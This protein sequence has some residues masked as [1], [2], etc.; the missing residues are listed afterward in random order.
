MSFRYDIN[1][2]RAI[3]VIAVVI[4]HF[5]PSLLPGGFS[6]VDIFFVISGFLM[7]KII[8]SGFHNGD[9]NLLKFY[10]ARANRIIPALSIVCLV[11]IV[12]GWFYLNPLD[13]GDLGKHIASSLGFFSNIVYLKES[14]YFDAEAH[15]KWLLH[16]WSLSVEWQFYIIYP[17]VLVCLK[18]YLTTNKIRN[19]IL[20]SS[21]IGFIAS[22]VITY[23]WPNHAYY[24][25]PA[26]AWEMM[27]GGIAFLYP[28]SLSKKASK[29][30][31]LLGFSLIIISFFIYSNSTPWPGHFALLPV[32]GS[33]LIIISNQQSSIVT[34]NYLFQKIG[35][36]SYSIYLWHWPILL[37]GLMFNL[38]NWLIV[39]VI[40][41]ILIGFLSY[42]TIESRKYKKINSWKG[43]IKSKPVYLCVFL[44]LI[45]TILSKSQPN[46][47]LYPIPQTVLNSMERKHY[48]CFDKKR[49]HENED[50][51]CKLTDGDK[52]ILA[53]G[54]SHSYS[55]LPA[56]E[57]LAVNNNIE[58]FYNGYSGCPPVIGIS[59]IRNDQKER[60]CRTLNRKT[61]ESA[62]KNNIELVFLTAR[63]SYYTEG[64]Y[65]HDGIQYLTLNEEIKDREKSTDALIKGLDE[66]LEEYKNNNINVVL[67]LQVPMQQHNP[68]KIYF[69]SLSNGKLTE[70][71]LLE[72]S[73]SLSKHLS[74]QKRTND[75]IVSVV[76][77][78]SNVIIFDPSTKMCGDN[79]CP[80]G[81]E[82]NSYYF[83]D[84]H[85]SISGA[86]TL[87][88]AIKEHL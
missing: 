7:T 43:L 42:S 57:E 2:L 21:A 6:G 37:V 22:I 73:V 71:S 9:F 87:V 64:D 18:R 1:G 78:Y 30:C 55:L 79:I 46:K 74:F 41:S 27:V 10:G 5:S 66:T 39:G 15:E 70:S 58:L 38:Q 34:N 32:I 59:P 54:D 67:V 28:L 13:Y 76:K 4:F 69:R 50:V 53:V 23:N 35:Y 40:L 63:W 81:N 72:N 61:I 16:T 17:L 86:K 83:D 36:W 48:D 45:G 65:S 19:I 77:K 52:K 80:V 49:M 25:L 56:F 11:L 60:N 20:L 8:F 26:R 31:E 33:Y 88:E 85:L 24:L 84:D 3:A 68:D 62:L 44:I 51:L 82:L 75:K 47:Y 14:G 12:F 29:S